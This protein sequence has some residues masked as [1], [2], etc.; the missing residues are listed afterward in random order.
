MMQPN[1]VILQQIQPFIRGLF[2]ETCTVQ[3]LLRLIQRGV[4]STL[5]SFLAVVSSVAL[6][7]QD[8]LILLILNEDSSEQRLHYDSRGYSCDLTPWSAAAS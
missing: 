7:Q 4:D 8:T 3:F 6:S 1:S 2:C 5:K